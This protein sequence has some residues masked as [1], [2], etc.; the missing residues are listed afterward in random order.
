MDRAWPAQGLNEVALGT[1]RSTLKTATLC[2]GVHHGEELRG[3]SLCAEDLSDSV[4]Y[5]EG[6]TGP[7]LFVLL[8]M[9]FILSLPSFL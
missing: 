8:S 3:V 6:T 1:S 2:S 7:L 4:N 9:P 5:G